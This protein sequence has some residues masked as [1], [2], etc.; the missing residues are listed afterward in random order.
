MARKPGPI[1]KTYGDWTIDNPN[2]PINPTETKNAKIWATCKCGTHQRVLRAQL[3]AGKTTSCTNCRN[4]RH[5]NWDYTLAPHHDTNYN[6]GSL[7]GRLE[8]ISKP[9]PTNKAQGKNNRTVI[10]RC[11][12]PKQTQFEA[13]IGHLLTGNTK[14]CGCYKSDGLTNANHRNEPTATEL[15]QIEKETIP[16][17]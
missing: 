9:I 11:T 2:E 6:I 3:R 1:N 4:N 12:C 16:A 15:A 7:H 8:I 13:A 5:N 14:S 10:V 17:H